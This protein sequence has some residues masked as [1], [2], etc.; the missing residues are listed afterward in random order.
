ME[1]YDRFFTA[2]TVV[3]VNKTETD[4]NIDWEEVASKDCEVIPEIYF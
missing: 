1:F 4:T 2:S 3:E